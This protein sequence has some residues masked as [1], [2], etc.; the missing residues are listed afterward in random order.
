VSALMSILEPNPSGGMLS[1]DEGAARTRHERIA[2]RPGYRRA[3]A[4][5]GTCSTSVTESTAISGPALKD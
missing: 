4:T 5:I 2:R 3:A 1:T